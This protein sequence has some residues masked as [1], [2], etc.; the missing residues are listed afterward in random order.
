MYISCIRCHDFVT[1]LSYLLFFSKQCQRV[2]ILGTW[3]LVPSRL[4]ACD[5]DI[6]VVFVLADAVKPYFSIKLCHM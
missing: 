1:T 2:L 5:L 4:R 3:C 6:Q